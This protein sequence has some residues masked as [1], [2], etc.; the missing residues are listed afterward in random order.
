M[1]LALWPV[2]TGRRV[3]PSLVEDVVEGVGAGRWWQV[4]G[5]AG[6]GQRGDGGR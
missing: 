4:N 5:D 6:Q 1:V 2:G 3:G